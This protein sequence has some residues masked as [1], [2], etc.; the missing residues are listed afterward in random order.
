MCETNRNGITESVFNVIKLYLSRLSAC[1]VM[2]LLLGSSLNSDGQQINQYQQ[3]NEQSPLSST[4]RMLTMKFR[5]E[6]KYLIC[7][8]VKSWIVSH[9]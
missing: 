5:T 8:Q 2:Y 9:V 1:D 6:I 4:H 7:A 3:Q